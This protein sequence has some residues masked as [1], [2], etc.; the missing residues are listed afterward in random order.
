VI[1]TGGSSGSGNGTVMYD[2]AAHTGSAS[3]SGTLTVAW[4]TVT[5]SQPGAQPVQPSNLLP[6]QPSNLRVTGGE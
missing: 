3:R 5:I 4:R 1:I 2:V 6:A